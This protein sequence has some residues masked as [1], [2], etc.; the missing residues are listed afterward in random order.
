[1]C[2]FLFLYFSCDTF[3]LILIVIIIIINNTFGCD[4]DQTGQA[5]ANVARGRCHDCLQP[6]NFLTVMQEIGLRQRRFDVCPLDWAEPFFCTSWL[7]A[8]LFSYCFRSSVI[9]FLKEKHNKR[10]DKQIKAQTATNIANNEQFVAHT[11]LYNIII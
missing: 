3:I 10:T 8:T 6:G 9:G 5:A 11:G 7:F 2:S 1:M 4:Q